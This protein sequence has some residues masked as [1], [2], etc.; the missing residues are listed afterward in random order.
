VS[1]GGLF[2]LQARAE[3]IVWQWERGVSPR[4]ADRLVQGLRSICFDHRYHMLKDL[5]V[6]PGTRLV[7]V[8]QQ[9]V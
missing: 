7:H 8:F 1:P 6:M 9:N 5:D 2:Y 3:G 4:Y